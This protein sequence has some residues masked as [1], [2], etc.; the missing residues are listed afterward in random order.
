MKFTTQRV[1][2]I[3]SGG[4]H[5]TQMLRLRPAF[6]GLDVFYVG[7]KPMYAADVAPAPFYAIQDV[8]RLY[9]KWA[10]GRTV[11]QLL[12]ILLRERPCAVLTTG[13][14]PGLIAL[15][16]AKL[17]RA[18]VMWIDSIAN[19]E[20]LSLSGRHAGKVA[21]RWLTQWEHLSTDEGPRYEG[22]V[23]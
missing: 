7:V 9:K 4:G 2:V 23:L 22:S 18:R 1:M 13:S 3:A 5:W 8:S 10:I 12:W 16:L 11:M 19:V 17:L 15:R 20:E 6:E 14:L 21:D